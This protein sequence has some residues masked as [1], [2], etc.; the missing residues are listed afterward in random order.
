MAGNWVFVALIGASAS[1]HLHAQGVPRQVGSDSFSIKP[2]LSRD[3]AGPE[4]GKPVDI[5]AELAEIAR[6]KAL[7]KALSGAEAASSATRQ[8]QSV[9]SNAGVAKA[10]AGV[11]PVQAGAGGLL[12]KEVVGAVREATAHGSALVKGIAGPYAGGPD[13]PA[14]RARSADGGA[15]VPG[16]APP[17]P[18]RYRVLYENLVDEVLPWAIA[19]LVLFMIGFAVKAWFGSRVVAQQ[20]RR[21]SGSGRSRRSRSRSR[22]QDYRRVEQQIPRP[23]D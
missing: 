5:D 2:D 16:A 18:D 13:D 15:G 21:R 20:K 17:D 22:D 6:T 8:A 12:D 14:Q 23:R 7:M 4:A 11:V 1:A 10:T 19:A 3:L 9:E